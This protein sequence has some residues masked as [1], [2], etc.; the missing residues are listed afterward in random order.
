[1]HTT[2]KCKYS[3]AFYAQNT[4]KVM[5]GYQTRKM[6]LQIIIN[7]CMNTVHI[8]YA[9]YLFLLHY[10]C[11]LLMNGKYCKRTSTTMMQRQTP[12]LITDV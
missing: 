9:N 8:C 11:C 7:G 4:V 1:M 5:S 2:K 3:N 6:L 12:I 10:E